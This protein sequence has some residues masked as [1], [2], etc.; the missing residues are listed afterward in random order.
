MSQ[1]FETIQFEEKDNIAFV[2]FNRPDAAN[3]INTKLAEEFVQVAIQITES[4]SIQAVIVTG[5]GK[6][7]SAGGDLNSFASYGDNLAQG[8]H[9]LT[10]NL[11]AGIS[12]LHRCSAPIVTAINGTAAGAGVGFALMADYAIASE[13]AKFNLAYANVGLSP[14]CST[15]YFLPRLVGLRKA[16]EL[17][18]NNVTVSAQEALELG[19]VSKVVAPEDLEKEALAIAQKWVKGPTHSY[20]EIK[21]LLSSTFDHSLEEQMFQ[22]SIS[23]TKCANSPEGKE[24]IA[25]FLEKRKPS[26]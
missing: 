23:I 12:Y 9:N 24:G 14:D 11:H 6:F 13:A 7:F 1:A 2:R 15:S 26:F 5:E 3:G 17:M 10:V 20:K 18:L 8:L 25:A 22:E 21:R 4:K 16:Q 19:M